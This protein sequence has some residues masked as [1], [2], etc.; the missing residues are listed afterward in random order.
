MGAGRNGTQAVPY[1]MDEPC[2]VQ[3]TAKI[4]II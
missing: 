1:K 3:S 2:A 4:I